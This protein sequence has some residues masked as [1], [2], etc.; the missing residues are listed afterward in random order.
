MKTKG[1]DTINSAMQVWKASLKRIYS[2]MS[3]SKIFSKASAAEA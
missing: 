2:E 1:I 3:T